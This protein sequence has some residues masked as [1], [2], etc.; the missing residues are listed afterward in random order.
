M[1]DA[2][3][4]L[5]ATRRLG[6]RLCR[7]QRCAGFEQ[8]RWV[9]AR[10]ANTAVAGLMKAA[11]RKRTFSGAGKVHGAPACAVLHLHP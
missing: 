1:G 3:V 7:L 4:Y 8:L 9:E 2:R 10:I 5:L 11:V 6:E